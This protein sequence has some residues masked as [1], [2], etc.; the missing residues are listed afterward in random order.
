MLKQ[1]IARFIDHWQLVFK[2]KLK[3]YIPIFNINFIFVSQVYIY[4]YTHIYIV[5]NIILR[6]FFTANAKSR[7]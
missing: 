6:K 2:S 5:W 3:K 1:V 7:Y 4:I